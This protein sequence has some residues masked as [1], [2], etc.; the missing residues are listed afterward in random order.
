V[1]LAIF[2]S[3]PSVIFIMV[4]PAGLDVVAGALFWRGNP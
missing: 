3:T 1:P 4:V 2:V